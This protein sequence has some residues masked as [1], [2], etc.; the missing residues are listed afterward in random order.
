MWPKSDNSYTVNSKIVINQETIDLIKRWEG[1]RG[2]AYKDAVGVWTIGYG[3]TAGAGVGIKPTPGMIIS[4]EEAEKYLYLALQKF[5]DLINPYIKRIPNENQLGAM[6]SLAYNIGPGAFNKSTLLKKWN[7]GDV[8]GAAEQ[9][10]VWN[11]AAGRTLNGL[12]RRRED[13]KALFE[14]PVPQK[15]GGF[16]ELI[17]RL[18]GLVK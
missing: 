11:K 3:T 18:L 7:A 2:Q 4:E 6:L 15:S 5:L 8:E 16:L 10:L 14:K 12:K 13:E 17:L 9:F 1:F